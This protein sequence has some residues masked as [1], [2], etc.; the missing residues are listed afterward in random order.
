MADSRHADGSLGHDREALQRAH[1][2]LILSE[3]LNVFQTKLSHKVMDLYP[4]FMALLYYAN[5]KRA[6]CSKK[7]KINI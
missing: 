6:S 4:H 5:K 2:V 7:I 1:T 3:Q